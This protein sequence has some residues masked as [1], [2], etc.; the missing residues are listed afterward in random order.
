MLLPQDL[1]KYCQFL[2]T[3]WVFSIFYLLLWSLCLFLWISF[4]GLLFCFVCLQLSSYWITAYYQ[5]Y[6]SL[7][8]WFGFVFCITLI[9]LL[10]IC[11]QINRVI[12]VQSHIVHLQI[13]THTQTHIKLTENQQAYPLSNANNPLLSRHKTLSCWKY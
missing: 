10:Q 7:I 3:Y 9:N 12:W 4:A 11:W 1:A 6:L 2:L 13:P 5:D 8:F